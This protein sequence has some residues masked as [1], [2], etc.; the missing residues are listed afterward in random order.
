MV[1]SWD[2]MILNHVNNDVNIYQNGE[3]VGAGVRIINID[4]VNGRIVAREDKGEGPQLTI[5]GGAI[6]IKDLVNYRPGKSEYEKMHGIDRS[7]EE[8][9]N[10]Y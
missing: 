9:L 1:Q 7:P 10:Y 8:V 6:V 3:L 4:L 5:W 2:K